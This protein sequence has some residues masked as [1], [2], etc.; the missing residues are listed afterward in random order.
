MKYTCS[1]A[2]NTVKAH[3]SEIKDLNFQGTTKDLSIWI[4]I[5]VKGH[6]EGNQTPGAFKIEVASNAR[7]RGDITVQ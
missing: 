4:A 3:G 1:A 7:E 5:I 2:S 6:P